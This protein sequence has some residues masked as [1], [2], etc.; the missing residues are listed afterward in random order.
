MADRR[1]PSKR[2]RRTT[3][4][5]WLASALVCV[6]LAAPSTATASPPDSVVTVNGDAGGA[7]IRFD[8]AGNAVDAHD[9]EIEK[10]GKVYYLYGTSYGCGFEWQKAGTP[11]CGFRSYTSTDLLNWTDRGNLFD[12]SSGTWQKACDGSTYGCYRPHVVYNARTGR[13]VLWFNSYDVAVGYH[14]FTSSSPSGHFTEEPTPYLG[15]NDSVP[16]G[17][18]NG[19]EDVFVDNDGTA[20]LAF[21]DWRAGGELVIAQLDRT[22]TTGTGTYLRLGTRS[23]E[24]PSMF[25]RGNRYYV[26]YSDPNCGFCTTGTSYLSAPSPLGPWTGSGTSPDTWNINAGALSVAGGGIGLSNAGAAWTDYTMSFRTTPLETGGGGKYAQAGWVFRASD[27]GTGYAWLLGNYPYAGAETGSLTKLVFR[28]GA[29]VSNTLVPLPFPVIGGQSYQVATTV[30]GS[31][32]TTVINGTTVDI[33]HDTTFGSGRIGFRESGGS[34]SESA[35][36]DDVRV[37]APDGTV[38]LADDFSAGLAQW[39]R[40]APVVIGTKISTTS[41]G[42]QPADVAELPT[43]AGPVYLYQSDR[44]NAGA[45]N[46]GQA[47]HYWEPL[48]FNPSGAIQPL[49]C[50]NS[51]ALAIS[52]KDATPGRRSAPGVESTGDVGFHPYCDTARSVQ[53]TQTFTV[54]TRGVLTTVSYSTFQAGHPN[55]PLRLRL[56]RLTPAGDPGPIIASADVPAAAVSWSPRWATVHARVPVRSGD[57]FALITSSTATQGCYGTTYTDTNP[58]QSGGALY[59]NDDGTTWRTET[60]RD[61]HLRATVR[62]GQ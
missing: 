19:D 42:G 58:Y 34:D 1:A 53:R 50:A 24:A 9:G 61:L 44:W 55:A 49:R 32:I 33:T 20:Y 17:V 48:R 21:T 57:Q 2:N 26:T 59:S 62:R 47:L 27:T 52:A 40:P 11:F 8:T 36:F 30:S 23:T 12:A 4:V 35:L 14:V 39:Q 10:F 29:V 56:A 7:T 25:R 54:H 18:N 31:T 16:V 5:A 46:E 60:G 38:L 45:P 15:V 28:N 51:Y 22:F 3:L 37:T 6:G 13:Y 41:C 43:R